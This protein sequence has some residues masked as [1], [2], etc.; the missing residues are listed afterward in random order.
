MID[1]NENLRRFITFNVID[2]FNRQVLGIDIVVS[3]STGRITRYLN[4]LAQYPLKIR[5]ITAQN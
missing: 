3:L 1:S 2:D 5:L 4:R